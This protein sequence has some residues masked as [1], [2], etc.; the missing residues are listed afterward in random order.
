MVLST[1]TKLMSTIGLVWDAWWSTHNNKCYYV[2]VGHIVMTRSYTS[3]FSILKVFSLVWIFLFTDIL[4]IYMVI[5]CKGTI[6]TLKFV[7][8]IQFDKCLK[9]CDVSVIQCY[10]IS[11]SGVQVSMRGWVNA[12]CTSLCLEWH[13]AYKI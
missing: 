1:A 10:V 2:L 9:W 4:F 5:G 12:L 13:L 6:Q 3:F 11:I 7:V 8:G